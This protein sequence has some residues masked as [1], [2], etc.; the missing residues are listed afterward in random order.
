VNEIVSFRNPGIEDQFHSNWNPLGFI[1]VNLIDSLLHPFMMADLVEFDSSLRS[2]SDMDELH[3]LGD[4]AGL[5]FWLQ[6][7]EKEA[8]RFADGRSGSEPC[9]WKNIKT[10]K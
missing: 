9:I 2:N 4:L 8:S 1:D 10:G 7:L 3:G 6:A 5:P